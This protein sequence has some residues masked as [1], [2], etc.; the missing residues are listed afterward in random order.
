[1]K[2]ARKLRADRSLPG[3]ARRRLAKRLR[4][5]IVIGWGPLVWARQPWEIR[6]ARRLVDA[7]LCAAAIS[8]YG[9]IGPREL[10]LDVTRE[11]LRKRYPADAM[12]PGGRVR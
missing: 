10:A 2:R 6:D 9:W 8:K 12:M 1:V 3:R 5:V 7:G 4:A 11:A